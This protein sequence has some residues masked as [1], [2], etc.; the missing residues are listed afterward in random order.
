MDSR[1]KKEIR[2]SAKCKHC[3]KSFYNDQIL[4]LHVKSIHQTS[5]NV[6]KV[7]NLTA[8][9]KFS[10]KCQHCEKFF[11][12]DQILSLHLKSVH[13]TQTDDSN[14]F[15]CD[16]CDS[17]LSSKKTLE[18]HVLAVHDKIKNFVCDTCNKTAY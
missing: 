14:K 13:Q 17:T 8:K 4:S 10:A 18:R 5:K 12:N 6:S 2:F 7:K 3:E 15:M 1:Q 11:F 16:R 9:F